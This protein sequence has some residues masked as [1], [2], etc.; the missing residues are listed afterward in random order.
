[1]SD[2][3]AAFLK[4][5]DVS[6]ETLERLDAYAGLLRRWNPRINLVSGRTLDDL[7]KRHFLDSAQLLELSPPQARH[8]CDLGAG[9]GFPGMVLAILAAEK[10]PGMRF[11]LI[12][13]DQRKSEFLRAVMRE[14][15][16][17]AN[18]VTD[19]IEAVPSVNA[20]VVSARALAPLPALLGLADAHMASDGMAIFPKGAKA[21]HEISE[22]LELWQFRCET[23]TSR[24][25]EA[26]VI[27]KISELSRA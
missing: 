11:T 21:K 22:A 27:L 8:W 17:T 4:N 5:L 2:D 26:A 14:T 3:Q 13:S 12:E 19:R 9:G 1:M 20:D 23:V 6:R 25:D 16:T 18:V 10:H 15:G 24:T 7:W